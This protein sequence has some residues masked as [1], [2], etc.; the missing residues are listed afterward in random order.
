MLALF[1]A[2][3]SH[4]LSRLHRR[5]EAGQATAEYAIVL[6]GAVAIALLITKWVAKTTLIGRLLDA[7][8]NYILGKV[9]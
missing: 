5:E 1:V 4:V 3:Q 7:V 8:L 2:V 9:R 6:L